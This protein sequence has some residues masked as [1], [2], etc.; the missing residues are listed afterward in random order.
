MHLDR[1]SGFG[2][3]RVGSF[4]LSLVTCM[5][6]FLV[7][8]GD[9]RGGLLP[10][11][12]VLGQGTEAVD[13]QGRQPSHQVSRVG[14]ESGSP[15]EVEPNR[16]VPSEGRPLS[17]GDSSESLS[18]SESPNSSS[19][20]RAST[21]GESEVAAQEIP[22]AREQLR[23]R[24]ARLFVSAAGRLGEAK[25]VRL[26]EALARAG[27]S[28]RRI[29]LVKTYWEVVA[30]GVKAG[31]WGEGVAEIR[32]APIPPNEI[33]LARA[34]EA[35]ARWVAE[36][37]FLELRLAQ[38]RLKEVLSWP[39][40][41][42]PPLPGDLLLVAEYRTYYDEV[43]AR[44]QL[45]FRVHQLGRTLPFRWREIQAGLTAFQAAEDWRLAAVQALS[46]GRGSTRE[47]IQAL[48]CR[49]KAEV[50]LVDSLCAYNQEI[51]EYALSVAAPGV[52]ADA[53]ATMLLGRRAVEEAGAPGTMLGQWEQNH[54]GN[55]APARGA[56]EKGVSPA[57]HLEE[58][59]RNE[60]FSPP[61][62]RQL[63]PRSD[64]FQSMSS[65]EQSGFS[66]AGMPPGGRE[67]NSRGSVTVQGEPLLPV[68]GNL[69]PDGAA[70]EGHREQLPGE[71]AEPTP[72]ETKLFRPLL[73]DSQLLR[74]FPGLEGAKGGMAQQMVMAWMFGISPELVANFGTATPVSF[75]ACKLVDCLEHA[76]SSDR[77]AVVQ[78]YWEVA[79]VWAHWVLLQDQMALAEE[80][81]V[82][83]FR[84]ARL[85]GNAEGYLR[86]RAWRHQ[87]QAQQAQ[88][89]RAVFEA[90]AQLGRFLPL[91]QARDL[92]IPST[93]PHVGG[94]D[95]QWD[96]LP[97]PQ[98]A[99]PRLQRLA[100][101]VLGTGQLLQLAPE[102]I[103]SADIAWA[104]ELNSFYRRGHDI[105]EL[106]ET[107]EF[108]L[109]LQREWVD[110]IL[111][112]NRAIAEY[113]DATVPRDIP[114]RKFAASLVLGDISTDL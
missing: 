24:L 7:L 23:A 32:S 29:A 66:G 88:V 20:G 71:G 35:R 81:A 76:R 109:D 64:G 13:S 41:Q 59:P 82:L 106:L 47:F 33:N 84:N 103:A 73:A 17:A 44:Q 92:L 53:L 18:T 39:S 43:Y 15:A 38:E 1:T 61:G 56:S 83:L 65:Q 2:A 9:P 63:L 26:R 91:P 114:G 113:A 40:S 77:L 25:P 87:L 99:D 49:L 31:L 68:E 8:F 16:I 51:A 70:A 111:D 45:P 62:W 105:S 10:A 74:R 101:R 42:V 6:L 30:A 95:L 89:E 5:A 57:L 46:Q 19:T 28:T 34:A 72:A 80:W 50:S 58:S 12:L 4:C 79:R 100:L 110:R 69:L 93:R 112:Y 78:A 55:V 54:G 108:Y 98:K 11:A 94:Y 21:S 52:S 102:A 85:P 14:S 75:T 60:P 67:Q 3:G 48:E 97:E 107:T 27:D 37:A 22:G 36:R 86:L 96:K 90:Q 104:E